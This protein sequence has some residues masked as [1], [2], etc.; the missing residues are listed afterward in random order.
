MSSRA[1]GSSEHRFVATSAQQYAW[2]EEVRPVQTEDRA[3]GYFQYYPP[4]FERVKQK[5]KEGK[6]GA[7][8]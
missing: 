6:F 3:H 2:L 7:D 8:T 4:V 5:V 1:E